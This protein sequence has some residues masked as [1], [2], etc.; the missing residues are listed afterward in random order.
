MYEVDKATRFS[1]VNPMPTSNSILL[2]GLSWQLKV[3]TFIVPGQAQ[4]N[5]QPLTILKIIRSYLV[6]ASLVSKAYSKSRRLV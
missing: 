4:V 2:F 5:I 1:A 3:R 6:F